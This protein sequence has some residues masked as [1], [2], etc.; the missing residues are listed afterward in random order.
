MSPVSTQ[1]SQPTTTSLVEIPTKKSPETPTTQTTAMAC[2]TEPP[3]GFVVLK[4][5]IPTLQLQIK[6]ATTDNFTGKIL[7]GYEAADAWLLEKPAS[8]LAKVQASLK[9][10]N[11]GLVIFDAY[12]PKRA[13]KAMV[14]W[15]KETKQQWVLTQGYVASKSTHNTGTTVDLGLIDL[16]TQQRID[17]GTAFD[18]FGIESHT[19]SAKGEI[20]ENRLILQRAMQAEGFVPYAK[21]W[22][23]F[24][25]SI[26][27]A[28]AIDV[29]YH[30]E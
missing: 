9:E 8:A 30:C 4:D 16:T 14:D 17:M 3:K 26:S 12:R 5:K 2:R 10:Q 15:A 19:K 20:L 23:H 18:Y 1:A 27:G 25:Y 21:E 7:P 28:V 6:Y 29:V 24:G 22:W 13:S 11:L